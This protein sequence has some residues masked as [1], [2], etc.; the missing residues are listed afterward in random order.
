MSLSIRWLG[1]AKIPKIR[2]NYALEDCTI[3][4]CF[5]YL[6][7]YKRLIPSYTRCKI[8]I[9]SH[10]VDH[11]PISHVFVCPVLYHALK[12]FHLFCFRSVVEGSK[13]FAVIDELNR[14]SML[15]LDSV[16]IW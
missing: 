15:L 11:F 8:G 6:A 12:H 4:P 13:S 14:A 9:S 10:R 1:V 7:S 2:S 5:R 16:A 3:F